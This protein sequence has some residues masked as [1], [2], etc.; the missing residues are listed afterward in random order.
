M[1]LTRQAA[2]AQWLIIAGMFLTAAALWSQ[3]PERMP[4][5]WN[6]E[7]QVDRYGGKLEGL[8]LL[9]VATLG[10]G[11]LLAVLPKLDPLGANYAKFSGAFSAI[12]LAFAVFMAGIYAVLLASAFGYAVDIGLWVSL[13]I[14]ALFVVI[15][16][17]MPRIAPNWFVGVRTPWT[18]ASEL[19]WHKTHRLAGWFF[20]VL[21]PLLALSGMVRSGLL[22][23]VVLVAAGVGVV[24]LLAYSYFVYRSDP[25]R[26]APRGVFGIGKDRSAP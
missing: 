21:G 7:G 11:L 5:H 25:D 24:G 20:L 2:L 9:P 12:R 8:L 15:G 16:L 1:N 3:A 17:A 18:L 14:G 6:I 19:S 23:F 4:V 13:G 22:L 26:T 10:V